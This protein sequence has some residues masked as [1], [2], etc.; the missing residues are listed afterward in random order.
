[1]RQAIHQ[2]LHLTLMMLFGVVATPLLLQPMPS[3]SAQQLTGP[4]SQETGRTGI[5]SRR[6]DNMPAATPSPMRSLE[7]KDAQP[8]A[9]KPHRLIR[10][11]DSN[12]I[13]TVE[14]S[15][16]ASLPTIS[17]PP[18][19]DNP[20]SQPKEPSSLSRSVGSAIPLAAMSA[21]PTPNIV[22]IAAGTASTGS[23]PL[24]AASTANAGSSDRER[25]GGR[26]MR[27]LA[28]EMPRLAQLIA[29]P[30]AP[31][32]SVVP[33]IGTSPTS[34]SFTAQ[35]GSSNPA[36]Q[37]LTISN[38]G[39]GIL[40]WTA[41]D[42]AAWMSLS[43]S[44]GTGAG[45]VSVSVT[46]GALTA[47]SYSGTVMLSATGA[48]P[49]I[50]PVSFT[51]TTA[52]V[53]PAIG[54]SPTSFSFTAQ[55]G[56]NPATQTLTISNTGG[57][58]L[59][60]TASDNAA[61]L[62]LSTASGTGNGPTTLTVNTATLTAGSYNALITLSA[63][64]AT[65]VTVPV[66]LTVTTAPVAPAIGVSPISLSFTAQ[67]GGTNP[68]TQA[69]AISN[70]GGG[71][72]TWTASDDAAWLS[73]SPASGTGNG[74][75][76]VTAI[77]GT[78][79]T[80]TYNGLITLSATGASPVSVPVSL[81]V[82]AAP[83]PPAIGASPT[84]L[85]FAATQG[86]ANPA[87]Q[88]LTI[89]NTGGGTL[90]WS[91]SDSAAWLT[92]SPISG[93]GNGPVTLTAA[94]GSLTAGSYSGT[95]TI[96]ATGATSV[97]IPVTFVVAAP[98]AIGMSPSSLSF[99]A[100]QGGGNPVAQT[101]NI[102]NTGGGTLSWSA[103]PDTT[104]LAATPSSATGNG[105]VSVSV[106]TGILTAGSYPGNIT[107][108]ATGAS[109]RT[110]P[111]TFT[112]TAAPSISLSPTSLTYTATQGGS[113]PA[114]QTVT[115]TNT[116]GV[117]TWTASNTASWLSVT[118]PSGS[119]SS[120]LTAAVNTTGLTAGTYNSTITVSAPGVTSRTVAVTL[121][122]STP[123]TYSATLT[124]APSIA[125]D[126]A[127]YKIYRRTEFGSYGAALDT[128]PAGTLSYQTTG[129]LAHTSYFFTVTAYDTSGNESA[130]SNEARLDIP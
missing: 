72:L 42:S 117:A 30:S 1:M 85:T 10:K 33:A 43:S 103:T 129:L 67:Q 79:A 59:N 73:V 68:A 24:A 45:S 61:W 39:G 53:A 109:S 90:T 91:V 104:W 76:T 77:L 74:P 122:V 56:S 3:A 75:A 121:T 60:W 54:A 125:A 29:P 9:R 114:N 55:A 66:A 28:A 96:A 7:K 82:T 58:T 123:T 115:L 23:A 84:S 52:P 83:V 106:A 47:G 4:A 99:T 127:G 71:T 40:S 63:P 26:T 118:P 116:G 124:W 102:S 37:T 8:A 108:S 6:L 12:P 93:T 19:N 14:P 62:T 81:T 95:V 11:P 94:T 111:V 34:L 36:A 64:G 25:S 101:L 22:S 50:V 113:N 48:S 35:Q 130:Q 2:P 87:N 21:A 16:S 5:Q 100:Q 92:A 69:L 51:V 57:G 105:T 49:V 15:P 107:L 120:T 38:I 41:S 112:V 13:A 98:P 88:T 126:L 27:R 20:A 119:S 110:V 86:S 78:L 44:A 70:T 17:S 31:A 89:S 46:T 18:Q 65:S 97:I 80:G 32:V 128:V